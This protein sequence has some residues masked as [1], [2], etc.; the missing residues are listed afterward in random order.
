MLFYIKTSVPVNTIYPYL[1][2]YINLYSYYYK[3]NSLDNYLVNNYNVSLKYILKQ[4]ENNVKIDNINNSFIQ[5]YFDKNKIINNK[6]LE[7]IIQFL[8]YGDLNVKS[9]QLISKIINKSLTELTNN[10]GGY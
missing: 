6:R 4:L 7:N 5:V 2:R 3:N 9:P 8:E 1:K 10:L